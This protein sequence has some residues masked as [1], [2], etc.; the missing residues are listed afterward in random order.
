MQL[1]AM[2]AASMIDPIL[3]CFALWVFFKRSSLTQAVMFAVTVAIVGFVIQATLSM[4]FEP[5]FAIQMS[6]IKFVG[7]SIVL[8]AIAFFRSNKKAVEINDEE[9]PNK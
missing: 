1:S 3:L 8:C 9:R 4:A 6:L 2:L 5:S 7:A